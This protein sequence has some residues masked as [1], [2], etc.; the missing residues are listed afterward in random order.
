MPKLKVYASLRE[1][2]H[3]GWVWLDNSCRETRSVIKITNKKNS[4]KIYC[5]AMDF[6]KNYIEI[7]NEDK[8]VVKRYRIDNPEV[9]IVINNWYRAKLGIPNTQIFVELEI[10]T[11]LIKKW[12]QMWACFDHPQIIVRSAMALGI[13]S[14]FLGVIG[15]SGLL[16]EK[17][18][19]IID[20]LI[21]F[22][23][24]LRG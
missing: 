3:Q 22:F 16:V 18:R 2:I 11:P 15:A 6:D 19:N 10:K 14:V 1:D 12:G 5:E 20:F 17:Y 9:S 24:L 21:S 23:L 7:Y 4:K 8:S 13:I